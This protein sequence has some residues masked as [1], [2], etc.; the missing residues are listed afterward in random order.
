MIL[1]SLTVEGDEVVVKCEQIRAILE[2]A[3]FEDVPA[4]CESC[5]EDPHQDGG[6]AP[7]EEFRML[8]AYGVA[9]LP[10]CTLH[11]Y[12]AR[13]EAAHRALNAWWHAVRDA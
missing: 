5:H 1:E 10:C 9:L 12:L 4:C 7:P 3:G 11:R 2:R 6:D 8:P 13:R